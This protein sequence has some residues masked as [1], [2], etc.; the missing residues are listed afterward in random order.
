MK[1]TTRFT[2]LLLLIPALLA[3]CQKDALEEEALSASK[4]PT[5]EAAVEI[6]TEFARHLE[7]GDFSSAAFWM[8]AAAWQDLPTR[9]PLNLMETELSSMGKM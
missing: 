6:L 4:E 9:F 7:E 5:R 1:T 3:S 2:S 8:T